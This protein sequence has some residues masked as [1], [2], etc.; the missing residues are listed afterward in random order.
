MNSVIIRIHRSYL[1]RV[2]L[3]TMNIGSVR[4][5]VDTGGPEAREGCLTSLFLRRPKG[6][7]GKGWVSSK[8]RT[9]FH[10]VT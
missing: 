5:A 9:E 3:F 6:N 8:S 2:E 7:T 4:G 1:P 10:Q